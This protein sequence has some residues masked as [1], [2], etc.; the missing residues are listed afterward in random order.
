MEGSQM[1]H[2]CGSKITKIN[3]AVSG[4]RTTDKVKQIWFDLKSE[5]KK[6]L[7]DTEERG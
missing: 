2:S 6:K 4:G 7:P 5:A 3:S 1:S